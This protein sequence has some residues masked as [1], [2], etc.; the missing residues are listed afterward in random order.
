MLNQILAL[1]PIRNNT[2]AKA[3]DPPTS[4]HCKFL[5]RVA[6]L[7]YPNLWR[8]SPVPLGNGPSQSSPQSIRTKPI[9]Y[10]APL[11]PHPSL[12]LANCEMA[13]NSAEVPRRERRG[14][15]RDILIKKGNCAHPTVTKSIPLH[16]IHT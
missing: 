12:R 4:L 1:A 15:V 7:D 16:L 11:L 13:G 2:N 9:S 14:Q 5:G 3:L 10:K 6:S 8:V